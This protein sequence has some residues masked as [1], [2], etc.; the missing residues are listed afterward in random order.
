MKKNI[1]VAGITKNQRLK[2][3]EKIKN[4]YE[5]KGYLFIEYIDDGMTKS[6]AIFEIDENNIKQSSGLFTKIFL[7]FI[8]III[9]LI[10]ISPTK[11]IENNTLQETTTLSTDEIL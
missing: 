9:V 7:G 3:L 4:K 1:P 11:P 5:K 2:E 6:I 10:I 8:L